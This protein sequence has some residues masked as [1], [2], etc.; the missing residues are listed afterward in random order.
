MPGDLVGNRERE[1][2]KSAAVS[3]C[4]KTYEGFNH[5]EAERKLFS[6][7]CNFNKFRIVLVIVFLEATLERN[8]DRIARYA[9][10]GDFQHWKKEKDLK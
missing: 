2:I 3:Y 4:G 8:V 7:F 6:K 10:G 9:S 1:H 5:S